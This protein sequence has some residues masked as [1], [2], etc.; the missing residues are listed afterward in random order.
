[1]ITSKTMKQRARAGGWR[2]GVP[3]ALIARAALG[4]P[5]PAA[6]PGSSAARPEPVS[7][8]LAQS[9]RLA[10]E[11]HLA[12]H[13][14]RR[15]LE[16]ADA[17]YQAERGR[18]LPGV[19]AGL[20]FRRE[21]RGTALEFIDR[22]GRYG[23]TAPSLYAGVSGR[24]I[25]G[26][27][28]DLRL[29]SE[30]LFTSQRSA[31]ISPIFRNY[32]ELELSHPLLKDLGIGVTTSARES[33]GADRA[34]ARRQIGTA[35]AEALSA[36]VAAYWTLYGLNAIR[37]VYSQS[38]RQIAA[39]RASI[40]ALPPR[41]KPDPAFVNI[42]EA[43]LANWQV[44]LS[45]ADSQMFAA[46]RQ[47]L[48]FIY[49]RRGPSPELVRRGVRPTDRPN[50]VPIRLELEAL[51]QKATSRRPELELLDA[52]IKAQKL[53]VALARNQTLPQL[54]A[55]LLAGLRSFAGSQTFNEAGFD[56]VTAPAAAE[57]RGEYGDAWEQLFEGKLPLIELGLRFQMPLSASVRGEEHAVMSS[58]LSRLEARRERLEAEVEVEVRETFLR[59]QND[60]QRFRQAQLAYE[61]IAARMSNVEEAFRR[62]G[63]DPLLVSQAIGLLREAGRALA[64]AASEYMVSRAMLERAVGELQAFLKVEP[65]QRG[66]EDPADQ[67]LSGAKVED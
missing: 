63:I 14:A 15:D 26:L 40:D 47:L 59:A 62:R 51:Q 27:N 64:V 10:L 1:M 29:G 43:Q 67:V 6:P 66:P 22:R 28:Y 58:Q 45:N 9:A 56:Q 35:E 12:I 60:E 54:D 55:Y 48:S 31:V 53:R 38:V 37:V 23:E 17:V 34:A 32:L 18:F 20:G 36:V 13:L 11:N 16:Q 4:Q 7:L 33:A 65:Q 42:P 50:I 49:A 19:Y 21:I 5:S 57:I 8:T 24:V 46:E 39:H 2:Y 61:G 3:L 52:Q 41:A 25:T 44:E 30:L